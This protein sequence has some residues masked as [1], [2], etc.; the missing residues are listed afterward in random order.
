VK[1][2]AFKLSKIKL[3]DIELFDIELFDIELFDIE[4]Y[5]LVIFEFK[6]GCSQNISNTYL[7]V[8]EYLY[9]LLVDWLVNWF[10]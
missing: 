10:L 3:F 6:I 2:F 9:S 4:L 8:A 5:E 1:L 7:K